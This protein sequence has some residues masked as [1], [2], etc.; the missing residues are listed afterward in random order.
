MNVQVKSSESVMATEVPSFPTRKKLLRRQ[1]VEEM[2][3]LSCST[4]Y[5]KMEQG[6]FP[7][8]VSLTRNSVRWVEAEVLAW[9]DTLAPTQP[10]IR[11]EG[12]ARR[13]SSK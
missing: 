10:T 11:I 1:Q 4:I 8:P 12:R 5:R 7:R 3:G 2:T 9:M 6:E 13:A